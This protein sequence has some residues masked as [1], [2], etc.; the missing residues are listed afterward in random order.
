MDAANGMT[1][2]EKATLEI[3]QQQ[4][5][6]AQKAQEELAAKKEQDEFTKK[7]A[8]LA[9]ALQK[10]SAIVDDGTKLSEDIKLNLPS[11]F[12]KIGDADVAKLVHK[13]KDWKEKRDKLV[14][15]GRDLAELTVV[16]KLS[17]D[18]IKHYEG[19]ISHTYDEVKKAIVAIEQ[20]DTIRKLYTL[21]PGKVETCKLPTFSGLPKEDFHK[22]MKKVKDCFQKNRTSRTDM[23]DKLREVLKGQAKLLIPE[24]TESIEKSWEILTKHYG[25]PSNTMK[26]RKDA[27]YAIGKLPEIK[28]GFMKQ[29]EW[30][31]NLDHI[32]GD[33]IELGD[34]STEMER[35]AYSQST[36]TTVLN[37]FPG[38]MLPKLL[39]VEGE[40]KSK[41][42]AIREKI[43]G[44][45][46]VAQEVAKVKE[47]SLSEE[48]K[49]PK[50]ADVKFVTFR[51]MAMY[52]K[53]RKM[54]NCRICKELETK[55]DTRDL[56]ENHLGNYPTGCPRYMAMTVEERSEIAS[57]AKFCLKCHKS[58]PKSRL[59]RHS[60]AYK[61]SNEG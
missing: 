1:A 20:E 41:F 39:K 60:S 8:I 22:F 38:G 17:E 35:E 46:E 26:A 31:I 45:R 40:G 49:Q 53:P 55:G 25:D 47:F 15:Q 29:V 59:Q 48:P 44:F 56:Y 10:F 51:G 9:R 13:I 36:I 11:N 16:Y 37:L 5:A 32:L 61:L 30:Y 43:I 42:E 14:G 3:S 7:T 27:L 23:L 12:E 54:N 58:Q 19:L 24:T 6:L 28:H 2:F 57:S 50:K 52:A 21:E 33:I 34:R 4:L 18:R